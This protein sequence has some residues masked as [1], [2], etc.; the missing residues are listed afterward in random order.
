[1]TDEI[2]SYISSAIYNT[3]DYIQKYNNTLVLLHLL[4]F[5]YKKCFPY[6]IK[7]VIHNDLQHNIHSAIMH[8]YINNVETIGPIVYETTLDAT[9]IKALEW[10]YWSRQDF[11][12]ENPALI[13]KLSHSYMDYS[14]DIRSITFL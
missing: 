12:K 5:D 1:M 11:P 13:A 8:E 7:L 9:I 10:N 14:I 6:Q 3:K 2:A 4:P